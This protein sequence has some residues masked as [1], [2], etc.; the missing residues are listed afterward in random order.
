MSAP[1]FRRYATPLG[2]ALI[3]AILGRHIAFKLQAELGIWATLAGISVFI[4]GLLLAAWVW[5]R[6][7]RRRP[8]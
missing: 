8:W 2:I 4:A 3:T 7:R 5:R 1:R 6:G